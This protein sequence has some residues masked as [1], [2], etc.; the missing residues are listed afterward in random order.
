M[1]TNIGSNQERQKRGVG[2]GDTMDKYERI[3]AALWGEPVDPIP[4]ALWRHF[5]RE[6]RDPVRLAQVTTDFAQRYDLD[7]IKLTPSGLY[8][9]EDWGPEIIYPDT[10]SDPPYLA[11]PAVTRAEGWRELRQHGTRALERELEFIR[12]TRAQ[13]G[14]D[15]PMVMTIF[16]PLT[17][18]YKL[19][20]DE[21]SKHLQSDPE[22]VKVGL[23]TLAGVTA[24]FAH[25]ALDAGADGLFFASQWIRAD[26]CSREAYG[27]FG[28]PYDLDVLEE[29]SHRSRV[30]ILHLHGTHVF[31]E[32]ADE[33]PVDALSWH[34]RETPPSLSEAR[35]E[36]D[37]AFITGLDRELL[38]TGPSDAIVAQAQEAIAQTEGRGLILAPACV[39]P[40]EAPAAHLEVLVAD[41][42]MET[43]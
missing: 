39:I 27:I 40:P 10:E 12:L 14:N 31:F 43:G 16:S 18:A 24:A 42:R 37:R 33:Y 2:K 8:A 38:L 19:A 17:L 7:L 30:T 15:W 11:R 25:A 5:H 29:V 23:R 36:T 28:L 1:F 26:V 21:L 6:D 9:V 3:Q 32:L 20:G 13:L 34:D 22:A 4:L 41:L 35:L